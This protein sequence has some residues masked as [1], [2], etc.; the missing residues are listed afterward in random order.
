MAQDIGVRT[1]EQEDSYE[2]HVARDYVNWKSGLLRNVPEPSFLTAFFE[3]LIKAD[4]D[5]FELLR[6]VAKEL[7]KKYGLVCTCEEHRQPALIPAL[8]AVCG[9]PVPHA[10]RDQEGKLT[11]DTP[12]CFED[13]A[14]YH[15]EKGKDCWGKHTGVPNF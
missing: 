5:N 15:L 2:L 13:N 11:A 3:A 14:V 12:I 6:P 7:I 1:Y 10:F 9:E 8:C 4:R